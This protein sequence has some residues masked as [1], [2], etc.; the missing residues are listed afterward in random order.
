MYPV[1]LL[2]SALTHT[3]VVHPILYNKPISLFPIA[4]HRAVLGL[5]PPFDDDDDVK[6]SNIYPSFLLTPPFDDDDDVKV[7]GMGGSV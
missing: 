5:T 7:G 2:T 1:L 6:V 3:H 4:K